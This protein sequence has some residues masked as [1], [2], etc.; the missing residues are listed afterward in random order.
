VVL[1]GG[2]A[3]IGKTSLLRA[4]RE[5][6][7][8]A[9]TFLIGACEPL[10]VPVP[11]GPWRE[12]VE[13]ASGDDLT[14]VGSSDR[15]VLARQVAG[16]LERRAPAV[17]AIED[18]HW[19][20]PLT[21]DL[22]RLLARRVEAIGVAIIVTFR[23]DEVAANPALGLLLGDLA[24][25]S[26]VR[27]LRLEPLSASAVRELAVSSGLDPAQLVRLTGGN[28]FLVMEA[29]SAGDRL[30]A[31]VRDAVLART[32]RL[33]K[34]A[35]SVVDAAAVIGQRFDH[36]L[37]EAVVPGS[38]DA[39]EEGLARGVLVAENTRLGFRHELIR[40]AIEAAISPP[41]R[42]ELH[43]RVVAVLTRSPETA[44]NA[45]LAHH[46]ELAGLPREA[47]RFAALASRE[48]ERVGALRETRLQAERA[49]RLGDG[50]PDLERFELLI[51]YSRA[52]NFS[53]TRYE[54]AVSGAE[55][56][57]AVAEALDDPLRQA[58][59]LGTLAWA[60]WSLD[61]MVEAKATAER[62][63]GA[64]ESTRDVAALARAES[65][66]AR[67]EA[68][69]FDPGAAI[70][71]G[72]RAHELAVSA[73][74]E[75]V[76]IDA[77]ISIGLARGHR[78]ETAA[79]AIL[80]DALSAARNSG[81]SIQA[82]RSYVNLMFVAATLREHV[83][84]DRVVEGARSF[85]EEHDAPIPGHV[86]ECSL[87]RSLLDR[88][89][90]DEALRAAGRSARIWH[91]ELPRVR[92]LEGLVAARRGEPGT[93]RVLAQAWAELPHASE[94]S[95]HNSIRCALVE[96]AWLRGD[97]AGA[98]EHLDAARAS[99]ATPRDVPSGGE[100]AVWARR[101]GVEFEAPAG[102]PEPVA[103][104]LE[105][106]WR[107]AIRAWRARSAPYE[108]ALAALDGDDLAVREA[109]ATL[110]RL[111]ARAAAQALRRERAERGKRPARGP[112]G[113]TLTH[114]A[115]LTRREQEVLERLATGATNPEIAAALHLS[116]R[117]V[118]HHV[119]AILSKLGVPNRHAAIEQ[120]RASGL[121]S[122]NRTL[123]EPR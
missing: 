93:E 60:L 113:S 66:L 100:L 98:L 30:P 82:V 108:A 123:G 47:S 53:S 24:G 59:A 12:I 35:R 9:A 38:A 95:R 105:G 51:R 77:Q 103:R 19:A 76:R 34:A 72:T 13:A 114:P 18:V 43:A 29:V 36:A 45:R 112:R 116:G 54:D 97:R 3:G 61:R 64:L 90:W 102:V 109:L 25:A 86:I 120:A 23:E 85:C 11:L 46:A 121:V 16:A 57:V 14:D 87:A 71:A 111:G 96:A 70:A 73:G 56:A 110:H 52:A 8:A 22:L 104:E 7:G 83:W 94:D 33:T 31:S 1:V 75:D 4:L 5:R 78:G 80:E 44:D 41:R 79:L 74:L 81:M 69:A 115:G 117:T 101:Y 10:S 119:S 42:A 118:A 48:A 107:G 99:P 37:L 89:Q 65:T 63:I 27:R 50:L 122:Q 92:A 21:L 58:H 55:A 40:E 84:V 62:A 49:L 20:D 15:L 91:S 32:G 88:G 67:L 28:P 6:T 2:E 39:V 68:T 26:G 106:D 17:A